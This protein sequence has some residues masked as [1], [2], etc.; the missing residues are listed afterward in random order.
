M[1]VHDVTN[2]QAAGFAA[3]LVPF[4]NKGRTLRGDWL[5]GDDDVYIVLGRLEGDDLAAFLSSD[6]DFVVSSY[7]TPIAWHN[8]D[9]WHMPAM[10]YSPTTSCHQGIIGAAINTGVQS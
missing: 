7:Q 5:D 2:R 3:E 10:K 9:G 4:T 6:P 1:T 8:G